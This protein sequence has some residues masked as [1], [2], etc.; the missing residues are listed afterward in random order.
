MSTIQSAD[1]VEQALLDGAGGFVL[2]ELPRARMMV[3]VIGTAPLLIHNF[4]HKAQ[5]EIE[6]SQAKAKGGKINRPPRIPEVEFQAAKYVMDDPEHMGQDGVKAVSFKLATIGG[7]RQ[8]DVSTKVM[9]MKSLYPAMFFHAFGS[10]QLLP[11]QY[12]SCTM[13]AE[14][15]TSGQGKQIR[16]RPQYNGWSILL[17]IDF[18]VN[19]LNPNTIL[20]LIDAG[21]YGGV[22]DWRP[23]KSASGS[24]G[25]FAIDRAT[26]AL[27]RLD[28]LTAKAL[29]V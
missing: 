6:E 14:P 22:G 9:S 2:E 17:T 21:G 3:P 15:V 25:T 10:E 13:S 7:L 18:N 16:Y 24:Y 11:I 26:V 12:E 27:G 8:F 20:S 23:E 1:P 19:K 4:N 29:A 5:L 28:V